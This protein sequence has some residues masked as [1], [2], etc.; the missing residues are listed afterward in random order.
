MLLFTMHRNYQNDIFY[1][2]KSSGPYISAAIVSTSE[3]HTSVILVLVMEKNGRHNIHIMFHKNLSI[4]LKA[5][6]GRK[7]LGEWTG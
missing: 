1:V 4:S 6:I 7:Y 5:D 2:T 3:I